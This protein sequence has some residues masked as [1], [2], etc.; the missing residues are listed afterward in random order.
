MQRVSGDN[1][2]LALN[3]A[4]DVL[5]CRDVLESDVARH[6]AKQRDPGADQHWNARDDEPMN[7]PGSKKSLGRGS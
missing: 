6:L 2:I 3:E 4:A 1:D 5:A 7:E